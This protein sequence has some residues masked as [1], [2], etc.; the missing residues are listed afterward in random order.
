VEPN[1]PQ[2]GEELESAYCRALWR[3]SLE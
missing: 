2:A 1:L 3:W